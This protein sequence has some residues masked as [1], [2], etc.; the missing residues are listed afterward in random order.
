M[1]NFDVKISFKLQI[2]SLTRINYEDM[3]NSLSLS[4][5]NSEDMINSSLEEANKHVR[6]TPK[7][8]LH[9]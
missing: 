4:R 6:N 3:I 8:I 2:L 7:S 9:I 5:I 1:V